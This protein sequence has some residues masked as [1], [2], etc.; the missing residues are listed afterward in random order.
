MAGTS[1]GTGSPGTRSVDLTSVAG[2]P[3]TLQGGVAR[4]GVGVLVEE[5]RL[6]RLAELAGVTAEPVGRRG[7]RVEYQML[8]GVRRAEDGH[9]DGLDLRYELTAMRGRPIG[10]ESAKTAGHVHVRPPGVS[11]GY[12]EI[13]EVLHGEAG[14]LVQDLLAGAAGPRCTR[15]WLVRA[16][17]GDWVV[18][19]PDLAHVTIDLGPGPL[20]FSDVIDRRASG[21]YDGVAQAR[22]FAW[23]RG[24]D[25]RWRPNP[26]YE[27]PPALEETDAEAWSGAAG[28]RLYDAFRDDP[29]SLA[30]LSDPSRF[31]KTRPDLWARIEEVVTLA[32]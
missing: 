16:R 7:R 15:A 32:G 13:V 26:R 18:L 10:W 17:P 6:R 30:W 31:A 3:L 20:V 21:V 5:D 23:Y 28:G 19:P 4:P 25:G 12:P 29:A 27:H 11:L 22:G 8:N 2:L 14:F 1:T 24:V 9:L